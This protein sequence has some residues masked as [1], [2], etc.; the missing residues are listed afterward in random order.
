M[1]QVWITRSGGR[2]HRFADC[3]GISDGHAKARSEGYPNWPVQ[4]VELRTA[5]DSVRPCAV[6]WGSELARDRWLGKVLETEVHTETQYEA[7]FLESVLRRVDGLDPDHVRAQRVVTGASGDSYR[8]D[9]AIERPGAVPIA[10]EVDGFEKAGTSNEMGRFEQSR[11]SKRRNDLD[12]AG[13][14][15]LHFTN[16]DVANRPGECRLEI[17]RALVRADQIQAARTVVEKPPD[18][19]CAGDAARRI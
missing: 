15:V 6:C 7:L 5:P 11:A 19:C 12:A 8:L 1:T 2:Y 3:S 13:W 16:T 14:R 4:K 17:E 18:A 10:L 9:F